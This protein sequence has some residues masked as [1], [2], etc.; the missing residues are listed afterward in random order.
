[1][2][3]ESD[4]QEQKASASGDTKQQQRKESEREKQTETHARK[5]NDQVKYSQI[6]ASSA[7]CFTNAYLFFP[8]QKSDDE[9]DDDML[10]SLFIVASE[11]PRLPI[12]R[13]HR[14]R[15]RQLSLSDP[16]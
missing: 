7:P 9:L 12:A 1:M 15:M 8:I 10:A 3:A 5:S 11:S 14:R 6:T 2:L 16:S 13:P 4:S